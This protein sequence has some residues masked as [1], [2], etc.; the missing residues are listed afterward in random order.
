LAVLCSLVGCTAPEC[1]PGFELGS[2]GNCYYLSGSDS[3]ADS[4]PETGE[5]GTDSDDTDTA[6]TNGT[7]DL[8]VEG[9]FAGHNVII[10]SLDTIP[11]WVVQ[12]AGM[13]KLQNIL[14]SGVTLAQHQSGASW[15]APTFMSWSIGKSAPV[16]GAEVFLPTNH[17][18]HSAVLPDSATTFAEVL[19]SAGYETGLVTQSGSYFGTGD[20]TDQGYHVYHDVKTLSDGAVEFPSMVADAMVSKAPFYAHW[21]SAGGHEPYIKSDEPS[22][23]Y[24][25]LNG[26]PTLPNGLDFRQDRQTQAIVDNWDSWTP[27]QQANVQAQL[28]C[29]YWGQIA[30]VDS[31]MFDSVWIQL[32]EMGALD[33]TLVMVFSDHGEEFGEHRDASTGWPNY[34]H[35]RSTWQQ[36]SGVIGGYWAPGILSG[37]VTQV[38]DH[39]DTVPTILKALGITIPA[40]MTGVPLGDAPDSRIL[41]RYECGGDQGGA[42]TQ[43][44]AALY[45][46]GEI[47]H[48]LSS[49]EMQGYDLM[50]DPDEQRPTGQIDPDLQNAVDELQARSQSEHW[51]G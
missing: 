51:C 4:A 28:D 5:T 11:S 1:D 50:A 45:G 13:P 38:T 18:I 34:G 31:V 15:T 24:S 25:C 19:Q 2:D 17:D 16:A 8:T 3:V 12:A 42:P 23:Y 21:H 40:S 10:L 26:L 37:T 46:N 44:M 20:N 49:G 32:R 33:N 27:E 35:N 39:G 41:L 22:S 14:D 48:L 47:V 29:V 6:T 43:N 30:W 9:A 7:R 36:V